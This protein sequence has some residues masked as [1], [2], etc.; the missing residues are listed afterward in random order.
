MP[1]AHHSRPQAYIWSR[2]GELKHTHTHNWESFELTSTKWF[3]CH[4]FQSTERRF[5]PITSRL[6][7]SWQTACSP[8]PCVETSDSEQVMLISLLAN[9]LHIGLWK[10]SL[11]Q[12][13]RRTEGNQL[14]AGCTQDFPPQRKDT[15]S[16]G[17][18]WLA[19]LVGE[20]VFSFGILWEAILH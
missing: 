11:F 4:V 14:F 17:G 8:S 10:W 3:G 9:Q 20:G 16:S 19:A 15:I 13:G 6:L 2:K 5:I 1:G 18:N 12:C 7:L